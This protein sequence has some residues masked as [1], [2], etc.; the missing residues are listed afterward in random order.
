MDL[1]V[2]AVQQVGDGYW[3]VRVLDQDGRAPAGYVAAALQEN[4]AT[5]LSWNAALMGLVQEKL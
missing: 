3:L 5:V 1:P 4:A 2:L